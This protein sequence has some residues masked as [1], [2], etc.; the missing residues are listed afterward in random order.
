MLRSRRVWLGFAISLAFLALFFYQTDWDEIRDA[1]TRANYAIALASLP[2]YFA[3]IWVRTVRWQYLLRPVAR[4]KAGRL[5]PVVIIG[6]MANN[7]LPARAG[8]LVRAYV[9]GER[10]R[11]S[12][13][14]SLGTIAVDRLFDGLTLVPLL[15]IVIPFVSRSE[16]FPLPVVDWTINLMQLAVV[17]AALFGA[18]LIVLML[19]AFSQGLRDQADRL[20]HRLTPERLRPSVEGLAHSFFA[21]LDSLRSPV[22]L[23][24]A[25]AMSTLSWLLEATMYY[26]VGL[27]FDVDV[28]FQY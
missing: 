24:V 1:F 27:A 13:A 19:L 15:L 26:M 11:V 14:A 12:K 23:T 20:V 6:L 25:W 7:L 21:G 10:E 22:D 9:L 18:A 8:E 2:V 16:E 3:G 5:Y 4:V 17:M 28:G